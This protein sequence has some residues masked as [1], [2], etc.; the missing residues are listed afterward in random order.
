L[1]VTVAIGAATALVG[2]PAW[3]VTA[4]AAGSSG[5]GY[6][7]LTSGHPYRHGVVPS[8]TWLRAHPWSIPA[9]SPNELNYGGGIS[10]VGVTIGTPRIYLVFYGTQWGTQGTNGQGNV[11]FSND[12]NGMAP[13]EEAF[14][15]GLG[16]GGETWSGVMTQYC[17]G[18]ATGSQTCPA[19]AAHVGYPSGGA[20]AG[21]WY[22]NAAASPAASSAH[23]LAQVAVSAA[24]H[25]GNT[26]AA[27]NR[28]V[29]YDIISPTGTNPDSY[30]QGGFCA[31]HDYTGDSTM[32]GGGAVSTP[33]GSPIAF[34]NM[35]YVPNAGASCGAGFVNAGNNLDGVS[36][37]NGHEW[38]ET[39]TDQFPAG[40]WTASNGEEN[41]DLCAWISSGQGASQNISLTT[42]SFAVQSTWANDF[43]GGNGGCEV[44]HPIVGNTNTVTVTNP[45]SQ[46]STAGTAVSLQIQASDSASGQTLTYSASGLPAGLSINSSSG[47]ISGTPT[48]AGTSSVSVTATD[49]TGA[50]GNASFS[51]TV[52]P[53]VAN[54]V[55]VTNPGSQTSTVGTA[56]SLQIQASDSASGQT[57]TYSASGLPAGL[58]INSSSGL[59]SGTPTTTGNSSV[60]VTATDTTGA[61][62]NAAFSWT[63]NPVAG[64]TITVTNPGSQTS[65]VGTAVSLQIQASD[66]ASGQTLTYSASG[67]PAGLSIDSSSGLISGTPTTAGT[68]SVSVTA[69]D[70]T[71]A[72]GSASFSWTVNPVVANTVT[73]TNPGSQTSTVGT[74]VSLQIQASDSASGQ[75][76]TYSASGLPAGLSINSSSGLISGTPTAAATSSVTVTAT[77]TTSASGSATFNWTVNPSGGGGGIVNGGFEAGNLS[78][79][80]ASGAA[81]GVT[82]S[83]PHSGTYAAL[84]G[85]SSPTNGDSSIAQTFTAPSGGGTLTFWYNITCPDTVR[86]DWAT[87]TLRDNT[88]G[89]STTPLA[90]T[91]VSSSGWR[92]VNANL[93]SGQSYTLTLTSHDDNYPGDPTFTKYDDVSIGAP[94]PPPPAGITN[95]GFETGNLSPGWSP[96][97]TAGVTTSGVHSGL[98]AALL[99]SSSPTNGD[100]SI[101]QTF[102]V[103]AGTST[104]HF[105][106]DVVCPDTVT[107]DWATA[108]LK[109]LTT[110]VTTTLLGKTCVSNSGW[111]QI[112]AS[113]TAGDSYTLSLVSHDDNYPG[114]PTYTKY[115]DV[116]IS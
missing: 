68:S 2:A 93:A 59:I 86:Y 27:T 19:S 91:C 94:P 14:F 81:A 114:D 24:Q 16:N 102:S 100:S 28:S 67:L 105:W 106:Y 66:S 88:T 111:V 98:Y 32:D 4:S 45:G 107:Y 57:L 96:T 113:V 65:T 50:S 83:G 101:A 30:Q 72:S 12:P 73:V 22:D 90:K 77:D 7:S 8:L 103:A 74:A 112:N 70:T 17:Q 33:W 115:D 11:T 51:W 36:I 110:G 52:N 53:V 23:Q 54:T 64:N 99:G 18:V 49:T 56:V 108:T 87:A 6:A 60:T 80:T 43:N 10:G 29:Q 9:V 26:T 82:T 38:A 1:K 47:L 95:G 21:F 62:G 84:L 63:V 46:T 13:Y 78:G 40:G 92:Q 3:A 75:T 76:L 25:F 104:L 20:F 48:T 34:T 55:T 5:A 44:S 37:V 39:V 31:W 71:G 89:V 41:G 79:W 97:G 69:T 15:K 85:S 35:P 58:S 116:S 109:N 61:S 42:G